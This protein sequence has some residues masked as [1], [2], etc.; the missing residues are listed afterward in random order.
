MVQMILRKYALGKMVDVDPGHLILDTYAMMAHR[1]H[2][3]KLLIPPAHLCEISFEKF[4]ANPLESMETIYEQLQLGD[5]SFCRE[6]MGRLAEMEKDHP[7]TQHTLGIR[8]RAIIEERMNQITSVH[9][10]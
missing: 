1:Y 2:R 6:A 8:E 5:F 7:V 10:M 3:D 9:S 4:V